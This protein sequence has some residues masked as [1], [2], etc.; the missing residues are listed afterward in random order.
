MV[1]AYVFIFRVVLCRVSDP[2]IFLSYPTGQLI[3]DPAESETYL[4]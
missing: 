3:T 4:Q 1:G 2:L